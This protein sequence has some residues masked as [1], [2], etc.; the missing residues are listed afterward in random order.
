MNNFQNQQRQEVNIPPPSSVNA[1]AAFVPPDVTHQANDIKPDL[2][3][4]VT[5]EQPDLTKRENGLPQSMG[6]PEKVRSDMILSKLYPIVKK[7]QC[8][9]LECNFPK[10]MAHYSIKT[11]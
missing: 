10:I 5:K 7:S 4:D 3:Q 2:I 9:W 6:E 8:L 1:A 11:Q